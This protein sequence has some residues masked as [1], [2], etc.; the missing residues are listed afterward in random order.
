MVSNK[1]MLFY[2]RRN[3]SCVVNLGFLSVVQTTMWQAVESEAFRAERVSAR[4]PSPAADHIRYGGMTEAPL[5]RQLFA[6]LGGGVG[7]VGGLDTPT[8]VD[9]AHARGAVGNRIFKGGTRGRGGTEGRGARTGAGRGKGGEHLR[10]RG[11]GGGGAAAAAAADERTSAADGRDNHEGFASA[12]EHHRRNVIAVTVPPV[13]AVVAAGF[14]PDTLIRGSG[15]GG[16]DSN[17]SKRGSKPY[18]A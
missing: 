3:H 1:D 5:V 9:G 17:S 12:L 8:S 6:G 4:E 18:G 15:G 14:V 13:Q 11:E 2:R 16:G 10:V 7:G